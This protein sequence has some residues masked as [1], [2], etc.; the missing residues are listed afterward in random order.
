MKIGE[1][2]IS[3][4]YSELVLILVEYVQ[5][6]YS[7][8]LKVKGWCYN[9]VNGMDVEFLFLREIIVLL[10]VTPSI[11]RMLIFEYK[12]QL[13]SLLLELKFVIEVVVAVL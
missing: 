12:L 8:C 4:A 13:F 5:Q 11:N 10:W 3:K 1:V 6:P 2:H 7:G 9:S